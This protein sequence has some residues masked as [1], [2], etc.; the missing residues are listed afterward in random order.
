MCCGIVGFA[1]VT[2][3][4]SRRLVFVIRG[5]GGVIGFFIGILVWG[6]ALIAAILVMRGRI[7]AIG[8]LNYITFYILII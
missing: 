3:I 4:G 8:C 6:C 7:V 2:C 5:L 1:C